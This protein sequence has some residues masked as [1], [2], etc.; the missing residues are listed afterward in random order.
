MLQ[1]KVMSGIPLISRQA[2]TPPR[3]ES[4]SPRQVKTI[5]KVSAVHK[6]QLALHPGISSMMLCREV[7]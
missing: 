3:T 5:Q 2:A 7:M 4:Y 1:Q 6:R